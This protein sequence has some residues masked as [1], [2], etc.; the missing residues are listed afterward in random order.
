MGSLP[1]RTQNVQADVACAR[2]RVRSASARARGSACACERG[3]AA[4]QT[5]A[6]AIDMRVERRGAK[7][8]KLGRL[9]RIV[10]PEHHLAV[11]RR[12][13]QRACASGAIVPSL[14]HSR[15]R[16]AARA[17]AGAATLSVNASPA[18][19]P[20]PWQRS[21]HWRS[22][23]GLSAS[24]SDQDS[25][26]SLVHSWNSLCGRQGA[27]ETHPPRVSAERARAERQRQ[28]RRRRSG[29]RR[30]LCQRGAPRRASAARRAWMR[31]DAMA[32][33]G[34]AAPAI[35][36]RV[37]ACALEASSG[38]RVLLCKVWRR[39]AV[40]AAAS[41]YASCCVIVNLCS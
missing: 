20:A 14:A 35:P 6:V 26:G 10:R 29:V 9:H 25:G 28:R 13:R 18:Y 2:A 1:Q 8:A 22:G 21:S 23:S 4:G 32:L 37:A 12:G 16:A 41:V 40:V 31:R 36:I 34:C 11:R 27:G 3:A 15:W 30:K 24:A 39:Y 38:A 17:A 5:R 7:E 33:M 19:S